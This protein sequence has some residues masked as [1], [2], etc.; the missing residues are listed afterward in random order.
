MRFGGSEEEFM[1]GEEGWH[2]LKVFTRNERLVLV[3]NLNG[4]GKRKEGG[5][6]EMLH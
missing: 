4:R 1:R 5:Y 2:F 3:K 6:C